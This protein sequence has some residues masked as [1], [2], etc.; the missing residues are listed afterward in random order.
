[1]T[2]SG[3]TGK[4]TK[5]DLLQKLKVEVFNHVD[6]MI[7]K[8]RDGVNEAMEANQQKIYESHLRVARVVDVQND[9]INALAD[10]LINTDS[11]PVSEDEFLGAVKVCQD[12]RI[13]Q[14]QAARDERLR[15]EE[16][17]AEKAKADEEAENP[18]PLTEESMVLEAG[19]ETPSEGPSGYH[20]SEVEVFGG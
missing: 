13:A 16:E 9:R 7:N 8:L 5:K 11:V 15:K 6:F 3:K 12:R 4:P 17:A 2:G 1:M 18:A 20:P 10:L 19:L 14:I